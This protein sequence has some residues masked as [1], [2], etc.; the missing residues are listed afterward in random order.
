MLEYLDKTE[1]LIEIYKHVGDE[2]GMSAAGVAEL[3][4]DPCD[5]EDA[6]LLETAKRAACHQY[7]ATLFIFCSD[8]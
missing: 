4:A 2:P 3:L 6:K 1:G 8:P 5:I 7:L